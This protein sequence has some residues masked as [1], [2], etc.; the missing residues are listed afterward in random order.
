MKQS[1]RENEIMDIVATVT[2]IIIVGS[3]TESNF[4]Q[5][6]MFGSN[7]LHAQTYAQVMHHGKATANIICA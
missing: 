6:M 7:Q 5:W 2:F 1:A 3:V 4:N